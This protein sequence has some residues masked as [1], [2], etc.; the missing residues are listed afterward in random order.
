IYN[1]NG[2]QFSTNFQFGDHIGVG[3]VL[4]N[5]WDLSFKIQH[6]SNGGVKHPNPGGNFAV[7][8][9]GMAF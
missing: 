1:N 6:Y 7:I 5:G 4:N 3:Y 9:A 8:K 2:R